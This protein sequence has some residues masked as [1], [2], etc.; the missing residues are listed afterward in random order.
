MASKTI[1][2]DDVKKVS[3]F[4]NQ[5]LKFKGDVI[6][7][8]DK[9]IVNGRSILGVMSLDLSQ[10]IICEIEED[11]AEKWEINCKEFEV[12]NES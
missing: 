9:Y 8:H 10:P 4:V 3:N 12:D 5:M 1:L 11:E 6:V 7:R 2:L